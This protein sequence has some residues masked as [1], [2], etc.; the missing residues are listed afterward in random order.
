VGSLDVLVLCDVGRQAVAPRVEMAHTR[1][2]ALTDD[3]IPW[4]QTVEWD[5]VT[6]R[7][8]RPPAHITERDR[9]GILREQ[10][11]GVEDRTG[12]V[13]QDDEMN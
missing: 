2:R 5:A 4:R 9:K 11:L 12:T 6:G 1:P 8:K 7:S 10:S 13:W 3:A